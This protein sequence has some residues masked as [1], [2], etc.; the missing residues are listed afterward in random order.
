MAN[1]PNIILTCS[2][3]ISDCLKLCSI[4]DKSVKN[5]DKSVFIIVASIDIIYAKY[6]FVKSPQPRA[7]ERLEVKLSGLGINNYCFELFIE[8]IFA[9]CKLVNL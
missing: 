9:L 5:I 8:L 1:L 3:F 6:A 2:R 7:L 4:S